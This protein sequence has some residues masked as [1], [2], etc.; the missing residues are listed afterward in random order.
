MEH[1]KDILKSLGL[2][3]SLYKTTRKKVSVEKGSIVGITITED[4]E[5]I[6]IQDAATIQALQ[7]STAA[8]EYLTSDKFI[9]EGALSLVENPSN[10]LFWRIK[11]K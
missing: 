3:Y 8:T 10:E 7:E 4:S 6:E 2:S 1:I 9:H 5:I 11:E